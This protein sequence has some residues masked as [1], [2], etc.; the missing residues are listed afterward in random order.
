MP[1]QEDLSTFFNQAEFAYVA[2]YTPAVGGLAQAGT[3]IYD[4]NGTILGDFG[5]ATVSPACIF[6]TEQWPDADE[7][8]TVEIIFPKTV[9]SPPRSR[10]YK[11]RS[12][13]PLDDGA[14]TLATLVRA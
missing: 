7:N 8:D 6:P 10:L 5:V 14:I 12:V 11:L 3:V 1:M 2:A 4:E 13:Q 9:L